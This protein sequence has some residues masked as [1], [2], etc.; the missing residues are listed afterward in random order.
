MTVR[1]LLEVLKETEFSCRQ[2][3]YARESM[4]TFVGYSGISKFKLNDFGD[5]QYG[6]TA[7]V[8]DFITIEKDYIEYKKYCSIKDLYLDSE[9][10]DLEVIKVKSLDLFNDLAQSSSKTNWGHN[11]SKIVIIVK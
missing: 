6:W 8:Y 4:E 2:N 1:E 11:L 5:W 7:G 10:I 9:V 3:I